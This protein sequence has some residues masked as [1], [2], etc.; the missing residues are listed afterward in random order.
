[1]AQQVGRKPFLRDTPRVTWFLRHP[2]YVRYMAREITC[3]FIGG[4]TVVLLV[5]LMRLAQGRSAYESFLAQLQTPLAQGFLLLALLAAIYH[6]ITWFNLTPRAMPL[7]VGEEFLPDIVIAG[8]HYAAWV[9][10]TVLVLV[11][12]GVS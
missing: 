12:A 9:A 10:V 6:S 11:L 5:G 4:F 8:A 7:Q 2:R 1:M 3:F